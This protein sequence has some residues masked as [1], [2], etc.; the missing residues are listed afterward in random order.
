MQLHAE[1]PL[2]ALSRL[3]HFGVA[4][5][6]H[7]LRGTRRTDNRGIHDRA[8]AAFKTLTLQYFADFG[9][10]LRAQIVALKKATEFQ[11]RRAIGHAFTS[12]VDAN[13]ASQ[14]GAVE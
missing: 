8:G 4:R 7:V 2:L 12:Q 5:L 10:Q 1:V 11:Q 9:E 6:V 13:E 14:R 3:M